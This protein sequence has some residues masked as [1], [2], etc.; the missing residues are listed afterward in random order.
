[1]DALTCRRGSRRGNG[2]SPRG[3]MMRPNQVTIGWRL[4]R[5]RVAS[6]A[7]GVA[8]FQACTDTSNPFPG[9]APAPLMTA[10]S[11]LNQ[12][13]IVDRYVDADPTVRVTDADGHPLT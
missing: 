9:P 10:I 3:A 12:Q 1:M 13:A 8:A 4:T 2:D 7:L 5:W 6:I 11:P